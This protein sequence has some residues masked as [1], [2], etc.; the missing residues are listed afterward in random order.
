MTI[1]QKDTLPIT[2]IIIVHVSLVKGKFMR[3]VSHPELLEE[4]SDNILREIEEGLIQFSDQSTELCS[5]G[6]WSDW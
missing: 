6:W 4:N 3:V 5:P 2:A 1:I